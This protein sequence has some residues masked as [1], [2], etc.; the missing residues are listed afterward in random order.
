MTR[1]AVVFRR[2]NVEQVIYASVSEGS[3][4]NVKCSELSRF[5]DTQ[6]ALDKEFEQCPIPE[7]IDLIG[8]RITSRSLDLRRGHCSRPALKSEG[9]DLSASL[10]QG[11]ERWQ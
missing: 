6:A 4:Q 3:L 9:A 7:P 11:Q 1:A 8:P 5:F 2:L 10:A